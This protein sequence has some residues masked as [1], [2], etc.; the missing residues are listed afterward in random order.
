MQPGRSC[1][2]DYRY[3]PA[4]VGAA[5]AFECDTLYVIGGLYGNDLALEAILDRAAAEPGGVTLAF[6][7]DFHWFDRDPA[8][9]ARI[10]AAVLAHRAFRGNVETELASDGAA[11][12]GCAYPALVSDAEVDRSNR[13]MATL[14]ATAAACA[15]GPRLAR[16]PMYGLARVADVRIALVHG[17]LH[18]LAGWTYAQDAVGDGRALASDCAAA[19]VRVVASSHTCLPVT[20]DVDTPAGRCVLMNNGAAG[21]PNFAATGYGLVTRIATR[22]AHDALYGTRLDG[23]YVDA[24]AVH[25]D[26]RRWQARFLEQWPAGSPA[27]DSYYGRILNGPQYRLRDAVRWRVAPA[28]HRPLAADH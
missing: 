14:R 6:N 23:L 20:L 4:T 22:P 1:P 13:I 28:D 21:M 17:D 18:S 10:D 26:A 11:G 16:L 27:H 2:L 7:G 9:F 15:A 19:Q 5:A 25:Y 3:T 8:V 12:C 24:L